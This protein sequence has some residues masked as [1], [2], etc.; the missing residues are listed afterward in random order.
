V[1]ADP[2]TQH[3]LLG[4]LGR[5]AV[6]RGIDFRDYRRETIVR[7]LDLRVAA[8]RS[9]DWSDYRRRL[10]G[11]PVEADRLIEAL[12]V[13]VTRFFRDPDVFDALGSRFVPGLYR[14]LD[15]RR[16]LRAWVAGAATGEEAYSLAMLLD[17]ARDGAPG[18]DFE[19]IASDIDEAALEIAR[20][21]RYPGEDARHIPASH[22]ER[23]LEASTPRMAGGADEEVTVKPDL[24]RRVRFAR[25]DLMGPRLAPS[26]AVIA[27]FDLVLCRNVV[28]YF[29][30]RLQEGA[31]SRL[32]GALRAG[33]LL[34]LGGTESLSGGALDAFEVV[35]ASARIYRR[36]EGGG[37]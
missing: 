4:I 2:A 11:D 20:A 37:T 21:G 17:A 18:K 10:E 26:E 33:G 34:V 19:I 31:F 14:A 12:V 5:L 22:R 7:R 1:T 23:S 36:R 16:T 13:S 35:D 25:H 3:E 29:D 24:R 8:T 6:D 32:A 15:R 30:Q 28:I 27:A 9:L